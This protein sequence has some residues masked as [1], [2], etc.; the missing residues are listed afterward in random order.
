MDAAG[1][2]PPSVEHDP[3]GLVPHDEI[4][5]PEREHSPDYIRHPI[6]ESMYVPAIYLGDLAR[7]RLP[8]RALAP[9]PVIKLLQSA[10]NV[11]L[12]PEFTCQLRFGVPPRPESLSF[13]P[14][15]REEPQHA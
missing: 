9:C 8:G 2:F 12:F 15:H 10:A 6:P 1:V 4:D 5:L 7:D 13:C 14:A 11:S 3:Y